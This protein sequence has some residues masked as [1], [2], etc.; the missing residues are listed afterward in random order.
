MADEL[1]HKD[2]GGNLTETEYD[3]VDAHEFESQATGDILIATSAAQLS[4][5]AKG[6][7][8]QLLRMGAS[9][10]AWSDEEVGEGHILILGFAY[11]T[12]G[13]G[14]WATSIQTTQFLNALFQ[15]TGVNGDNISFKTY[16]EVGTYTLRLITYRNTNLGVM[17][18]DIDASEKASFDLYG[19][20]SWNYV[21]TQT[22]I[23]VATAGIKTLKVRAD[24]KNGSS[25]AYYVP[26]TAIALWRT[27]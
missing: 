18:I 20:L 12:I 9:I 11:S 7:N 15:S 6:T 23:T 16:L 19:G 24:G 17:D 14:T 21:Q 4:R 1:R 3:A 25:S 27:A 22:G 26:I 5:L 8:L 10:P 2:V 13:Q